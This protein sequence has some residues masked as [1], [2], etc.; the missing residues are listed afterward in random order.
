MLTFAEAAK[1]PHLAARQTYVEHHG[2]VQP[3][4]APR[5]SRTPAT[6]GSPP[7]SPGGQDSRSALRDWGVE[8]ADALIAA[9]VVTQT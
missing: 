7:A 9:G 8:D 6:L 2:V 4:P 5:F 1:G 3:A